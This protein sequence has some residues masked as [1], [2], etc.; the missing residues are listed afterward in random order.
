MVKHRLLNPWTS[1]MSVYFDLSM[2]YINKNF[3][4]IRFLKNIKDLLKKVKIGL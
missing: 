3:Y 1:N 2:I 4:N